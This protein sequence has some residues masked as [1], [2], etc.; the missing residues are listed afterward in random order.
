M[1]QCLNPEGT[2]NSMSNHAIQFIFTPKELRRYESCITIHLGDTLSANLKLIGNG[3]VYSPNYAPLLWG[4]SPRISSATRDGDLLKLSRE[5][6]VIK[7][8]HLFNTTERILFIEN[9][10]DIVI[11]YRWNR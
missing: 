9:I 5:H 6:I 11:G 2:I 7:S 3:I 1:I 4:R 8:L 10:S